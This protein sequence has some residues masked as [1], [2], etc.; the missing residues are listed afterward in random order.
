M[1]HYKRLGVELYDT[2]S[3]IRTKYYRLAK[4]YH[5][6]KCNGDK[7]K[8]EEFKLISEAY[9]ILSNPHTRCLYDIQRL[10]E[11]CGIVIDIQRFHFDESD[12]QIL[13]T[14]YRQCI[15]SIEFRLMTKLIRSLPTKDRHTLCLTD[16]FPKFI[17]LVRSY[18]CKIRSSTLDTTDTTVANTTDPCD[19]LISMS[20]TKCI[21]CTKL[22]EEFTICLYRD[23]YEVYHNVCKELII[24][25]QDTSYHLF[26]THSDYQLYIPNGCYTLC[27]SIETK[28]PKDIHL[29]GYDIHINHTLDLYEYFFETSMIHAPWLQ[30]PLQCQYTTETYKLPNHGLRD[31]YTHKRGSLIIHPH[32]LFHMDMKLAHIHKNFIKQLLSKK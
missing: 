27:L 4:Q 21:D 8:C 29:N 3:T 16:I 14:Y 24:K 7:H 9:S 30:T 12:K 2:E 10:T 13:Y 20:H 19:T 28:I 6:D 5:P 17:A 22:H 23:I 31:I 15:N 26:I 25:T 1:N 32:I 11:T 18:V